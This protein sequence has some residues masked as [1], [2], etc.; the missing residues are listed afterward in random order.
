MPCRHPRCL[1]VGAVFSDDIVVARPIWSL[2]DN[3]IGLPKDNRTSFGISC[4]RAP[5]CS[6]DRRPWPDWLGRNLGVKVHHARRGLIQTDAVPK[7]GLTAI[8][9]PI[10]RAM[11]PRNKSGGNGMRVGRLILAPMG[12]SPGKTECW[13]TRRPTEERPPQNPY[14]TV[15][16]TWSGGMNCWLVWP[17]P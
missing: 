13:S 7:V 6:V 8:W 4:W 5:F 11:G 1:G 14:L 10:W 9:Q 12:T 3:F 16:T 2:A 17:V 15:P